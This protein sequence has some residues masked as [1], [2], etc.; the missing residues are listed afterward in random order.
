MRRSTGLVRI[1]SLLVTALGLGCATP[2]AGDASSSADDT[3]STDGSDTGNSPGTTAELTSVADATGDTTTSDPTVD[4]SSTE[5]SGPPPMGCTVASLFTPG[6]H[7]GITIDV[8]GVSRSYDLF[9][10]TT[11]DPTALHP[12][13]VNFHGLFG[14]P[15]QQ[16]DFSQFNPTAETHGM[17][18]AYPEGIGQSFNAGVCC[19][20]A[21]SNDVDDVGFARALVAD[22]ALKMCVDGTRV[23]ATGMSNGGHMAHR[24]ACEAADLFAATSSVAGVLSLAGPCTPSRPISITQY[25]G[26]ADTIVQYDG[27]PN[28]PDMMAAWAAR[29]GC[30]AV[31][32]T[33][34]D[35]GDT[36]CRTW[37]GCDGGVEVS[38]CTIEGG[39]HCW[40]GNAS[41]IFGS[42]T[43]ELHASE[44]IALMFDSQVLP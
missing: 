36:L 44:E 9:V 35:Q 23:Y 11:Y 19:G 37:P 42:S 22:V 33:T 8:N 10:P 6:V 41:C 34:F 17:L 38:L 40:P 21:S 28:V 7:T 5:D 2:S 29:N 12:L 43:T 39:G 14:T 25:H 30:A 4:P 18:V 26:T 24:L 32:E 1:P 27:F 13:V 15:P 16:A 3:T 20:Q 31:A